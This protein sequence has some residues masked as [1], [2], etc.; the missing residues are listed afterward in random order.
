MGMT[1]TREDQDNPMERLLA[2][3]AQLEQNIQAADEDRLAGYL[4]SIEY[5]NHDDYREAVALLESMRLLIPRFALEVDA[6][7]APAAR[8]E[9]ARQKNIEYRATHPKVARRLL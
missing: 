1:K 5:W 4:K 9:R 7:A 6:V 8:L 2:L 3:M